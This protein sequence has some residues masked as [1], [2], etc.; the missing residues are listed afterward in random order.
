MKKSFLLAV[1]A[2]I[3]SV[4]GIRAQ[5]VTTDPSPLTED[6][7]DVTVYFHADR[8]NKGLAGLPSTAEIYAHTG[9]CVFDDNGNA[10]DWKNAP[11]WNQNLPKF[12]LTY[13]SENLWKL[14]IGNIRTFYG[15][16]DNE[17]VTRLGFVFRNADGSQKGVEEGGADIFVNVQGWIAQSKPSA[18]KEV[19]AMGATRNNDGSVTFCIAA[20][21]KQNAVLIGSW[22]GYTI[23][24]N[25]VMEYID[26]V[27]EGV[28]YRYFTTTLPET[29]IKRNSTAMYYYMIDGIR[30]GDPYAH[31]VLDPEFDKYIPESV[32]PGL[33]AYPS[34]KLSGVA[35]SVFADDLNS[36][37]WQT[38]GFKAPAK[39]DLIIYELLLRDFTGTEGKALGNGTVRGAIEK[40]PYLKS[41][42]VNAVE[43]LPINEFNGN[44]SWGYNPNYYFAIDKAYGTPQDYKE[45]IDKCHAEGI[46]V[47]LD[48]VF[49]QSDGLHPWYQ[50][51]TPG[52]NPFY[53]VNAPHAYSVLNDWN[54]GYPLVEQQWKDAVRYWLEEFRVDGF[55]FDLVKGLGD[56]DSYS[57]NGEQA[58]NEYNASRVARM[59]R[60]HAAMKEVN[61]DAY[62]INENLAGE[63]EEN[64]MAADGELNWANVSYSGRAYAAGT[65]SNSGLERMLAVLD[66]RTAGSTVSYLESHDEERLALA[67]HQSTVPQIKGY[68]TVRMQR[69]GSAAAQMI[70]VPGS[71]MIWQF[72]EMGNEQTT[73]NTNGSNNTDPKIVDWG[74]LDVP[75]NKGLQECYSELIA[76]RLNNKELFVSENQPSFSMACASSDWNKGRSITAVSADKELYALINP[77]VTGTLTM[78]VNFARKENSAYQIL[79]K[80]YNSA[81]AFDAVAGTVSVPA[82]CYVVVASRN[83]SELPETSLIPEEVLAVG[84]KGLIK[85]GNL[86]GT[87]KIFDLSGRIVAEVSG[88][89]AEVRLPSGIYVVKASGRTYKVMVK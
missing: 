26:D 47:I 8:G 45:F 22:N 29:T 56:N 85:L 70:L 87:A 28:T 3:M 80:A 39:T 21:Q 15:L 34:D 54:Q 84:G 50:L 72:S 62:F 60:I 5:V 48:M 51:Y 2:I 13:V 9:A 75:E 25:H 11:A 36:Y 65:Q 63:K 6:A 32:Y 27:K 61:P 88:S 64:E 20:P 31:L 89:E 76:I 69:L 17:T 38:T 52:Q 79:S 58:T 74:L 42:G 73:K 7:T 81:P 68:P 24:E 23:D 57:N 78:N 40:I 16:A 1:T 12:K 4:L 66:R 44:N 35:L 41:L 82:N 46:A 86:N 10:S 55:R 71:H 18:L 49:N 33:P 43:L 30:V 37:D 77:N 14:A 53:N 19:P 67:A 83:V 59:K